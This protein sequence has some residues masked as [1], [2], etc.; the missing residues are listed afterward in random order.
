M[1]VSRYS[2]EDKAVPMVADPDGDHVDILDYQR[3]V[4]RCD[5]AEKLLDDADPQDIRWKTRLAIWKEEEIG[6]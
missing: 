1:K 6:R 5:E 4:K 3:L 2:P